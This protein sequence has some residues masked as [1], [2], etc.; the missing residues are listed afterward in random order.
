METL[1]QKTGRKKVSLVTPAT[2][3]AVLDRVGTGKVGCALVHVGLFVLI[4]T[5]LDVNK[6][7]LHRPACRQ[8]I[9]ALLVRFFVQT[10]WLV[11]HVNTHKRLVID[12]LE[13]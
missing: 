12:W 1:R 13:Q 8:C 4:V 10:S 9:S 5:V 3:S 2:F 6:V 11:P 7:E